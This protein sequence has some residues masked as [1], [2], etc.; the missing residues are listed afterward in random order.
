ML[1]AHV[2]VAS[3]KIYTSSVVAI[4]KYSSG[5]HLQSCY[6]VASHKM[7]ILEY[8]PPLQVKSSLCVAKN[9]P[10]ARREETGIAQKIYVTSQ[11]SKKGVLRYK[12]CRIHSIVCQTQAFAVSAL[13]C[14]AD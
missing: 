11:G 3:H 10:F 4:R 9:W 7:Y 13:L 14:R 5:L 6:V 8:L 1:V 12:R 2:V